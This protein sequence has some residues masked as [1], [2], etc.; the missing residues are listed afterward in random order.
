MF[1][2]RP[3]TRRED[4]FDRERE[5]E[6]L[7]RGIERGYPVIAVLGVRRIG[8]TSL[9]RVF[10][11]E[12]NGLYVDMEGVY[13]RSDL[14]AKLTEALESSLTRLKRFLEGVRGWKYLVYL[15]RS[16]GGGGT[17]LAY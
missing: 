1:D 6:L 5:L 2:L 9:L 12:V 7:Y 4:L 10:L 16:G 13:R 3:K 8:K 15:F 14:E 17:R 11:S